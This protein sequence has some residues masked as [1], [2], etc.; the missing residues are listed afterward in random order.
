MQCR[1]NPNE[2]PEQ[3]G[4]CC[5][6]IKGAGR[7]DIRRELALL[8]R[9]LR[10]IPNHQSSIGSQPPNRRSKPPNARDGPW[11]FGGFAGIWRSLPQPRAAPRASRQ[12]LWRHTMRLPW[13]SK[14]RTH[15]WDCEQDSGGWIDLPRDSI[16][17]T[18]LFWPLAQALGKPHALSISCTKFA[19]SG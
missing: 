13:S 11:T 10:P 1:H 18:S 14:T 7:S 15:S 17:A 6:D 4:T 19:W 8:A 3:S 12:Q 16:P 9:C 2:F 5:C